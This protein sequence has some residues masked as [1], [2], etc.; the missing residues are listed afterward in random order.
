MPM[1]DETKKQVVTA[2]QTRGANNPCPRCQNREFALVDQFVNL[3][4]Q[5]ELAGFQLGGTGLPVVPIV[6]TNCGFV[7]LHAVG[8]LGLLP[9]QQGGSTK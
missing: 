9:P 7:A 2:L 1:S 4:L 3:T 8:A 5:P 6:C